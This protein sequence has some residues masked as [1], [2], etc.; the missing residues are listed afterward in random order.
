MM[1]VV[2]SLCAASLPCRIVSLS[3]SDS[4]MIRSNVYVAL[5]PSAR[6]ANSRI[7]FPSRSV[8]TTP[9]CGVGAAE[10]RHDVVPCGR[11]SSTS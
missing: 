2:M 8:K 11:S 3:K 6:V 1:S 7:R 9:F 10:I 4:P 5:A